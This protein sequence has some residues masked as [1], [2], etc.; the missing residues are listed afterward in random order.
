MANSRSGESVLR[1][2]VK[3]LSTFD[4]DCSSRSIAAIARRADL[5]LSTTHRLVTEMVA[6]RLLVRTEDGDVRLGTRLW[7]LGTAGSDV[8]ALREA[9]LPYMEDVHSV[10]Q[11]HT[12]LGVLD[13][14]EML[15]IERLGADST[16]T[17]IA[18]VAKRLPLHACSSGLVLLAF[19]P[20]GEQ[21]ELL[22]Q[23]IRRYT[24]DTITNPHQL[25]QL[26]A[27]VRRTGYAIAK[28][29]IVPDSTGVAVPIFGEHNE[30]VA[31]LNVIV[32]KAEPNPGQH[33]AVLKTAALSISRSLGWRRNVHGS[34]A[35]PGSPTRRSTPQLE[36]AT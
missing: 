30:I 11:Q 20:V 31:A 34:A 4:G 21:N 17:S 16:A 12:T 36:G 8:T 18:R 35:P 22:A 5:P 10:V 1:R 13:A 26:L 25:R 6:E 23:P 29:A 7:E 19:S 33:V 27:E 24:P 32:P 2:V 14:G 3:V 28:G 9:A 15:Y